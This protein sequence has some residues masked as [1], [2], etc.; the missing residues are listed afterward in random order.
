[1]S[2]STDG[3]LSSKWSWRNL[4]REFKLSHSESLF[5]LYQAKLQ[6]SFFVA[7]LILNIIFNLGAIVS[8][9]LS[10]YN[11]VNFCKYTYLMS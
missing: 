9:A 4:K 2:N 1:M 5:H 11:Q 8:Y 3:D 6:H 7:S 10:K